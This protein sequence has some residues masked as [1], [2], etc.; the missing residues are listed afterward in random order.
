VA[1]LSVGLDLVP[2]SN[3]VLINKVLFASPAFEA[4]MRAG[5]LIVAIGG[6][7]TKGMSYREV[8]GLLDDAKQRRVS[9]FAMTAEGAKTYRLKPE[10]LTALSDRIRLRRAQFAGLVSGR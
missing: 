4:G 7:D 2:G 8:R 5:D 10:T 1:K 6:R 9:I 3:G